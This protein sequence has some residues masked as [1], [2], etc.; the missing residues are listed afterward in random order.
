[1]NENYM[2]KKYHMNEHCGS[3][4]Y[5]LDNKLFE[6]CGIFGLF[7]E[8]NLEVAK[9]TY[10]ALFALQHRGQES[11]GIAVNDNGTIIYYKDMGLVPEVYNDTVLEHLKG[12]MAIGHIRYSDESTNYR[13]NIQPIVIKY[14]VG[15]LAISYNGSLVN[16]N[17][18]R[19][20]MEEKGA[21]FQANNDAEI[22]ANLISR[23]R[24]TSGNI[25]EAL[26]KVMNDIKGGYS[27]IT[28]TTNKLIGARDP[29]GIK[30]LCIGRIKNSYILS[31]ESCALDAIGAEFVRDVDPGEIVVI[32]DGKI[33][34]IQG[35]A[36][37]G[38]KDTKLC[39][40]EFVYFARHDSY[41]DGISVYKTRLEAGKRLAIEHPTDADIVIGV[42]DSGLIAA[43]GY[44][45]QSGIPYGTGLI[46]NRYV[47]RTFIKPSQEQREIAVRIKFNTIRSEIEGKRIIMVDDSI[48]RGTTTKAIVQMLKN[49]GAKEVHI[50]ISSPPF[51]FPCHYGVNAPSTRQ[52]LASTYS[53]EEIR[54]L[55]G[56]DSL[57]YLS[58]EGLMK[59]PGNFALT[60]GTCDKT[61]DNTCDNTF[62]EA[63]ELR[64]S[65]CCACF[66]GEYP[67][68]IT[69]R[70][71][72]SKNAKL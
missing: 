70:R 66:S 44:S 33:R 59:T 43:M 29:L 13:E 46:K 49:A 69:C 67:I 51:R 20:D 19:N 41:I 45:R 42:P 47:G 60:N 40:F 28:L 9:L 26:L 38:A 50:R 4:H 21:V 6:E 25:E 2:N 57:E 3:E 55:I 72:E 32:E 14:K 54:E 62:D 18:I 64:K 34:S 53:L 15:Q 12:K 16:A 36:T 11:T 63:C 24:I 5:I 1:M 52:L 56:A 37:K 23:Y 10:Y 68:E 48:V 35:S 61:H 8:D 58:L 27:F 39:I 22:I 30:P 71:K 7:S 31:S 65:F 17:E